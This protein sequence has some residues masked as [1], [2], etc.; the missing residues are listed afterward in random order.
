MKYYWLLRFFWLLILDVLAVA[1]IFK[2]IE[3]F[4]VWYLGRSP[5]IGVDLY[6]SISHVSYQLRHFSAPFNGFADMTFGGYPLMFDFPHLAFYL[7]IPFALIYSAGLGV[8]IF[9]IFSLFLFIFCCY[10]LF[11]KLTQNWGISIFLAILI[12]L[13]VNIY[14][15]LTWAGSLPY[16]LAQSFLPLGLFFAVR[17]FEEA[18]AKNLGLLAALAALA[19]L[20]HPLPAAAYVI[21]ASLL[22][23]IAGG[24]YTQF[25][26]FAIFKQVGFFTLILTLGTFMV[27]GRLISKIYIFANSIFSTSPTISAVGVNAAQSSAVS[28]VAEFYKNQIPLLWQHTHIL[29]FVAFGIGVVLFLIAF[30]F[31]RHKR[32]S[33]LPLTFVLIAIYCAALPILNLGG[34][35]S[36]FSHDPYRAFWQFPVAMSALA[37][38]LWGFFLSTFGTRLWRSKFLKTLHISLGLILTVVFAFVA[39]GVFTK[40]INEVTSTIDRDFRLIE[41]SSA[42]P[43]ILSANLLDTGGFKALGEQLLPSFIDPNDRNKRLY[44]ADQTVNLWWS[45]FFDVPLARGYVDP[46]VTNEQRGG[47][48]WLDI[49]IAGDTLV[50]DFKLDEEV[51]FANTLFLIDWNGIYFFEGGRGGTKGPSPGPSSYL[52][53][54]NIFER[55]EEVVTYGR[56]QKYGTDSGIPEFRRDSA[57]ILKFF[58][59]ADR[60]TSPILYPTNT[61]PII[62]FG[63]RASY[64]D[65][66]RAIAAFNLNSKRLIPVYGGEEIDNLILSEMKMFEAIF[67][68]QYKSANAGRAFKKLEKYVKEGGKVFIDTGSEVLE[69]EGSDLGEIFPFYESERRGLGREWNLT[70]EKDEILKDVDTNNFGPLVYS[71]DEWKI[72]FPAG[73]LREDSKVLLSHNDR[74]VLIE[75]SLGKGQ[76]IWSGFNLI[77]HF[78]YYKSE[79]EAKLIANILSQFTDLAEREPIAARVAWESPEEVKI[80]VAE[81]PRGILFKEQGYDGWQARLMT[82]GSRLPIYLAGPSFP[83]AIYVPLAGVAADGPL[84][85][86]FNYSGSRLHWF[87]TIVNVLVILFVIEYA[88][89]DGRIY[90]RKTYA[91][92]QKITTKMFKWW[93]REE[94]G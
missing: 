38:A 14:G 23:I 80:E 71:E 39:Y 11:F 64:E 63:T 12:L 2:A 5:A 88:V 20:I 93:E 18:S 70:I 58:K 62:F 85:V 45:S 74:P 61:T 21:P 68:S 90:G 48:F 15:D 57:E 22:I 86:A 65:F 24:I 29:I 77:F 94:E 91:I 19:F 50:R 28:K 81:K 6:N 35:F 7:M 72:S 8:Q 92:G 40:G 59:V 1:V 89:F 42:Y 16:F 47:I 78:N 36:I 49:A 87:E 46:P 25:S 69:S 51:A 76:V 75:R 17:Y 27:S 82:D 30:L 60:F 83:G 52:L 10:L 31:S 41:F 56:L 53:K 79:A 43:E 13:S 37:A 9:A 55:E 3:P 33:I 4:A 66:L 73:G 84:S 26:N 32:R 54:D 67:A 44:T 34:T